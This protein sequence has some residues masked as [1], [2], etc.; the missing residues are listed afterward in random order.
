[1][2]SEYNNRGSRATHQVVGKIYL[3]QRGSRQNML[4]PKSRLGGC[5]HLARVVWEMEVP[6]RSKLLI[7]CLLKAILPVDLITKCSG[8][9][10]ASKCVCW[11]SLLGS[12]LG[13]CL[14]QVVFVTGH[15]TL[16]WDGGP[17]LVM[18]I[19]ASLFW[20]GCGHQHMSS[21]LEFPQ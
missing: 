7:W 2:S 18:E 1:M 15:C 8:V 17:I 6:T 9:Q 4:R 20:I 16:D 21:D 19:L 13:R 5:D 11:P 3:G 10:L 14:E 12:T